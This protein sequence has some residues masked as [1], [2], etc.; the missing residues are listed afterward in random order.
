M[1]QEKYLE[2]LM[3]KSDYCKCQDL[4]ELFE[5][6]KAARKLEIKCKFFKR[7]ADLKNPQQGNQA[8]LRDYQI[9]VGN[10]KSAVQ[11]YY[12]SLYQHAAEKKVYFALHDA[13]KE[14]V[15]KFLPL[16]K[17]QRLLRNSNPIISIH[18]HTCKQQIDVAHR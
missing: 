10:L 15:V 6:R 18:C 1:N 16:E 12:K 11:D 3:Q 9:E 8:F 2:Q 4:A 13:I 14:R 5:K 7:N 17:T